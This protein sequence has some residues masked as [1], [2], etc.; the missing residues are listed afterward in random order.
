MTWTIHHGD[1]LAWLR[2]LP[3]SSVDSV[4][5]DPP[6]G[7]GKPPPIRDVLRAWLDGEQYH[8]TGGGFMGR[9]WDAY[10]PGPEVWS[11]ICRVLKPGG[12]AVVFAGQRTAD[13]MAIALRLGGLE[14][15][16]LIGWCYW[17][18]FPKSHDISKGIDRL[19]GAEREVVG[20]YMPPRGDK[21]FNTAQHQGHRE[22]TGARG[23]DRYITAPST[24]DA[25]RWSGFGTAL[26]PAIE[27]CWLV[28]KPLSEPTIALNVLRW[29]T[30]G[31]NVD[32][33]RFA[34]GD[35]A[36]VGPGGST[37]GQWDREWAQSGAPMA[38]R[39]DATTSRAGGPVGRADLGRWPANLFHCP[40]AST[41]ERECGCD[42]LPASRGAAITERGEGSVGLDNPRAG[43]G[44][45][46][47]GRRNVHPTVKPLIL[48][49]WIARLITPPGGL[50]I[51]PYTGSGTTG[52]AAVLEGLD[53]AG[54]ELNNND[55]PPPQRF[56][57]IA[58]ARIEW[59][60]RYG[61]Q[62]LEVW[63][64]S[65]GATDEREAAETAGQIGLF[66]GVR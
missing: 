51:D 29:G 15:R 8:A 42:G 37:D 13:V 61:D 26:K 55:G 24:P 57:D 12:H 27:P 63:K 59:W 10:V 34:Y 64:A 25:Q 28:R 60:E 16:D 53:F 46:S 6:Y 11:E 31:I 32:A 65:R 33:C 35:R 19:H 21:T 3:D 45:T 66:G 20:S 54:A 62:A 39:W 50:V 30:G 49:R 5:T 44:R 48:M 41:G 58:T 22:V 52:I 23:T 17:S 1:C 18:G 36:W 4:V 2:S 56:V 40:K 43:A 14:V 9:A 38:E 7:L 47:E